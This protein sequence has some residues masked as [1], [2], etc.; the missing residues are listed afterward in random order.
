MCLGVWWS[1]FAIKRPQNVVNYWDIFMLEV[2]LK[3]QCLPNM[4]EIDQIKKRHKLL[5][6][7]FKFY[8]GRWL[9]IKNILIRGFAIHI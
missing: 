6:N 8:S 5:N 4:N 2:F 1:N 7:S 9:L 3:I